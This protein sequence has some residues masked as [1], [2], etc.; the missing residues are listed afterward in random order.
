[1]DRLG[2][3]LFA[4]ST[5]DNSAGLIGAGYMIVDEAGYRIVNEHA[6]TQAG[7]GSEPAFPLAFR[8]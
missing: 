7:C 5:I 3:H 4:I 1:L 8:T 2:G 6:L